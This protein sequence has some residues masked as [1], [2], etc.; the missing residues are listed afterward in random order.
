[1][2]TALIYAANTVPQDVA[3]GSSINFGAPVR[4]YGKNIYLSGGNVITSGQGYYTGIV[5]VTFT[6]AAGTTAIK[7]LENGMEIPGAVVNRTTAAA[8]NYEVDIPFATRNKCCNEKIISVEVTGADIT[9][10]IASILVRKE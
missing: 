8:T 6:G 1:M 10:A 5:H 3:A 4:R 2:S 7:V 9:S